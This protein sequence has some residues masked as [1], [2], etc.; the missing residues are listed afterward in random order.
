[1]ENKKINWGTLVIGIVIGALAMWAIGAATKPAGGTVVGAT[2]T[3]TITLI[4]KA[5]QAGKIAGDVASGASVQEYQFQI[6]EDLAVGYTPAVNDKVQFD[7]NPNQAQ[8]VSNIRPAQA[9]LAIES[10]Y[11]VANSDGSVL[12]G[13]ETTG[14]VSGKI[15]YFRND[16]GVI[17]DIDVTANVNSGTTT[18]ASADVANATGYTIFIFDGAGYT[19]NSQSQ[20]AKP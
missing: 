18:V 14:A 11:A 12:L 4:N 17:Q 13:W 9:Q 5:M 16:T 1:M 7:V 10:F 15:R 20:N 6:P 2:Y 8:D 3:G 19:G